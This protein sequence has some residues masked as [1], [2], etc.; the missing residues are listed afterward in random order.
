MRYFY[1]ASLLVFWGIL[2]GSAFGHDYLLEGISVTARGVPTPTSL[3]PGSVGMVE[4][5]ELLIQGGQSPVEALERIPGVSRSNDSPWSA[6]IVVRG[7]TRDSVLVLINGMRINMTTD[8]NGR[9]GL[10][11]TAQID[12]IEVLKGPASALYGAGSVGGVINIITKGG[13]FSE[14]PKWQGSAQIS[15]S[16]NPG[17]GTLS[18]NLG[19]S[20][21]SAWVWGSVS[22]R[23][24]DSYVDGDGDK[25]GNSQFR[26]LSG[27][28]AAGLKWSDEHQTFFNV[29]ATEARDVGIPGTG[30]APLPVGADVTLARHTSKRAGITHK[31]TPKGS[32]L[33]ESSLQ[34]GYQ[35]IERRPRIDNFPAGNPALRIEPW[36]DHETVFADWRNRFALGSHQLTLGLEA[37]NWYM[38]GGRE[39]ALKNG[40]ILH[41][42][43]TPRTTQQSLGIYAEND[44]T[45][46]PDWIVNFGGRLDNVSIKNDSTPNISSGSRHDASWTAHLGLTH[47]VNEH[48]SITGLAASSYRTPN[49]LEL[50]KNISLGGGIDE[51]G[52]QDLKSEQSLFFEAGVHYADTNVNA[53]LAAYINS[54]DDLIVSAPVSPILYQMSNVSRAEIY[55]V[56]ASAQYVLSSHWSL[57]GNLAYT[58]GRDV[59]AGEPLRFIPPVNGLLGIRYDL[60]NGFWCSLESA[61]TAGQH[62]TPK[63]VESSSF[64]NIINVRGGITFDSANFHHN[65]NLSINNLLD[66]KYYN[67][68][69]TSRGVRL[70]EPGL[71]IMGSW[72]V[73]F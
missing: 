5:Q 32:L 57:L 36:A 37:W 70:A 2:T 53:E 69:A 18:T 49:I 4:S 50:F 26:D 51:I 73:S 20:T 64:Y 19:Y 1:F 16:T 13:N 45:I 41:D 40:M 3:T 66:R 47:I 6:D 24:H 12:R 61:W 68:L 48:W 8:I 72:E 56:E 31:F 65:L 54:V 7:M 17:G 15:G 29:S 43:P 10:I 46:N 9:F 62:D 59:K 44:W 52:N 38:T 42:Q 60:E 55:G 28:L 21:E 35:L 11:P 39:R 34:L 63:G 33:E 30:T 14:N 67:Y 71:N 22:G 27:M 58:K 25:V 23:D